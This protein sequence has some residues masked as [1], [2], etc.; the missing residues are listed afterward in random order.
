MVVDLGG[1]EIFLEV[2]TALVLWVMRVACAV[3][4]AAVL[5]VRVVASVAA[6][7][8]AF[9]AGISLVCLEVLVVFPGCV[10]G[11]LVSG[12]HPEVHPRYC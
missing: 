9:V 12:D 3:V 7:K 11:C 6:T 1:T 2:V 10:E 8:I 5:E 4:L